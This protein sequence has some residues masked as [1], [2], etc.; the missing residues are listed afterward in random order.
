MLKDDNITPRN[1]WPAGRVVEV[2][3]DDIDGLVRSVKVRKGE[4]KTILQ[5]PIHKLVVILEAEC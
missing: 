4:D 1:K 5:R 3:K 2:F